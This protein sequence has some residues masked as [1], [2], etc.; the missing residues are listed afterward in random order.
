MTYI[1]NNLTNYAGAITIGAS[2]PSVSTVNSRPCVMLPDGDVID[3]KILSV[4]MKKME[5]ILMV[6]EEDMVRHEQYPALKEIYDQ[7][8]I[9]EKM[10]D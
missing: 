10:I 4:M 3:L 8:K 5:A 9:V 1:H 6:I 2:V 7:Y